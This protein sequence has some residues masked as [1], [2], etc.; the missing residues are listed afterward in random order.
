MM[1]SKSLTV[2]QSCST[3]RLRKQSKGQ[4]LHSTWHP[5]VLEMVSSEISACRCLGQPPSTLSSW[6]Q[7]KT[8]LRAMWLQAPWPATP[9]LKWIGCS[10]KNAMCEVWL[11]APWPTTSSPP[12]LRA[13]TTAGCTRSWRRQSV[14]V[15]T[16]VRKEPVHWVD[17]VWTAVGLLKLWKRRMVEGMLLPTTTHDDDRGKH[18]SSM[19]LILAVVVSCFVQVPLSWW[20][21]PP[22]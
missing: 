8:S 9:S 14:C 3:V 5:R 17:P 2:A 6:V 18:R 7:F 13:P 21:P 12:C 1:W 11:Q 20:R 10:P 16:W 15:P 19:C 4:R 22:S